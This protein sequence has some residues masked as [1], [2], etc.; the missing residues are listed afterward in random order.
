MTAAGAIALVEAS[1]DVRNIFCGNSLSL[2]CDLYHDAAR[3]ALQ[4][5]RDWRVGVRI[6]QRI[7]DNDSENLHH[8][9]W[10]DG[11]II[12]RGSTSLCDMN[13]ACIGREALSSAVK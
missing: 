3:S 7:V 8:A 2:I 9:C 10:V 13:A 5:E 4:M 6:F 1:K 11:G 12:P